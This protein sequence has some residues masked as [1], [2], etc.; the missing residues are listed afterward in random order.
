M[1]G[2][3]EG[4]IPFDPIRR[5]GHHR[6]VVFST[7]GSPAHRS[8]VLPGIPVQF[9]HR[10]LV[11]EVD[12]RIQAVM[13][14]LPASIIKIIQSPSPGNSRGGTTSCGDALGRGGT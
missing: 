4:R 9:A 10:D 3:D 6:T 2:V 5:Q 13:I 8:E 14:E 12:E 7:W 11:L 1:F